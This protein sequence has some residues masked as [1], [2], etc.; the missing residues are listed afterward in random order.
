MKILQVSKPVLPVRPDMKYGGVE[1]VVRDLDQEFVRQGHES[2]VVAPADSI[3]SGTLIPSTNRG[4][5]TKKDPISYDERSKAKAVERHTR[6]VIQAISEI[7]P[8][9]VHD[10]LP[11][12]MQRR[13]LESGLRVPTLTT[14]HGALQSENGM[15][16]IPNPT[17]EVVNL[18]NNFAAISESQRAFFSAVLPVGYMIHN[19]IRTKD[20]PFEPEKRDYLLSLGKIGLNKGQETAIKVARR[21]GKKLVIAGPVHAFRDPIQDYWKTKVEPNIDEFHLD[22]PTDQINEFTE[23]LQRRGAGREGLVIYVGEVDDA[24]KKEWYR[25]ASG[26]SMPIR[27][28][29]PFGLVMIEAMSTGTPVVAYN[30]GAVPEI[31]INGR[32]GYVVQAEN[33]EQFTEATRNLEKIDP[34]RTRD[35]IVRNFDIKRQAERYIEAFQSIISA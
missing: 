28:H 32:T 35:H 18:W 11:L 20:Y 30:M 10:H 34:R 29:E 12:L 33:I 7:K 21:L 25:Y 14:L 13:Y 22:I 8:D 17:P 9:V 16:S 1:R 27:W 3:V 19:A 5:W 15:S 24:Q 31:V 4:A 26:F 23:K 2:F 6:K